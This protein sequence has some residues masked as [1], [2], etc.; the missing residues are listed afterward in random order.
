MD[1]NTILEIR[2]SLKE[3]YNTTKSNVEEIKKNK[4][5]SSD[6]IIK[7]EGILQGYKMAISDIETY[8][9]IATLVGN[10]D[11]DRFKNK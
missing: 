5:I 1:K 10:K 4:N 2:N 11:L 9:N 3:I 7:Y 8:L 6:E